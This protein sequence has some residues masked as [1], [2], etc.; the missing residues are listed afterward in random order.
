MNGLMSTISVSACNVASLRLENLYININLSQHVICTKYLKL[1]PAIL[2]FSVTDIPATFF[3][4][5]KYAFC[6][7][8][9]LI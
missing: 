3:L 8:D 7:C 5:C 6:T 2:S 1:S 4:A 9:G